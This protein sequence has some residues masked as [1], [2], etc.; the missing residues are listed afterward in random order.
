VGDVGGNFQP[1]RLAAG[2]F[3]VPQGEAPL[4][5]YWLILNKPGWL[6]LDRNE[7]A[8]LAQTLVDDQP[9]PKGGLP[10][11]RVP[12]TIEMQFRAGSHPP[13][14]TTVQPYFDGK[15]APRDACKVEEQEGK[16]LT[17]NLAVKKLLPAEELQPTRFITHTFEAM[18]RDRGLMQRQASGVFRFTLRPAVSAKAVYLGDL[19]PLK[20]FAHGGL[21]LDRSY[22]TDYIP[23]GGVEYTKG[24]TT[25]PE[26]TPAGAYAEV[27]Y[28][29][30]AYAAKKMSFRALAGM[31]DD[32]AGSVQFFV[33]TRQAGGE[34]VE[35][36][37]TEIMK[38][39]VAPVDLNVPLE[40]VDELRLCVTD[41]GDGINSDHAVWALARLE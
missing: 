19:K 11:G 20:S 6:D 41:A 39:G 13:D 15:A 35:R 14:P 30:R 16:K 2:A 21:L 25:H 40:N 34:W 32:A 9:V 27:I 24:L 17:V 26:T 33:Y 36:A 23:L 10:E 3:V 1:G 31:P 8:T 7:P 38:A 22:N 37:K 4:A 5:G 28:D 12:D 18:F 29:V